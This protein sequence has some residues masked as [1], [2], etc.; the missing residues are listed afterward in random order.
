MAISLSSKTNRQSEKKVLVNIADSY[1]KTLDGLEGE[2]TK[3]KIICSAKVIV[4][5]L[6]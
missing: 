5:N 4:K 3:V 6:E 1:R 2:M